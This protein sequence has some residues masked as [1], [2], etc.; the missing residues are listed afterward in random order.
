MSR[1]DIFV[2]SSQQEGFST[3]IIE[4]MRCG[5]P[6]ISTDYEVGLKEIIK[7]NESGLI[8]PVGDSEALSNAI[9]KLLTSPALRE[10]F[11]KEGKERAGEFTIDK[12]TKEYEKLFL[13]IANKDV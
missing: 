9:I 7:D 5:A 2:L 10:K 6:V 8:V 4:A 11:G 1:A 12:K 13:E 3:V